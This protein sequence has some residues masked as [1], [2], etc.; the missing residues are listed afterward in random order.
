MAAE[1]MNKV[2]LDAALSSER[3]QRADEDRTNAVLNLIKAAKEI[4]GMDLEHF[5]RSL[6]IVKNLE[7]EETTE[8]KPTKS[9]TTT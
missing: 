3:M 7:G 5:E 2:K 9:S 1:R 8:V 4:Q 6:N